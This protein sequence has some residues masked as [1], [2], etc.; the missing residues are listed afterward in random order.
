MAPTVESFMQEIPRNNKKSPTLQKATYSRS[1][2]MKE[3]K[4]TE[5]ARS[6]SVDGRMKSYHELKEIVKTRR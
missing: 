3:K 5:N 1:T 2:Q 4:K 6:K